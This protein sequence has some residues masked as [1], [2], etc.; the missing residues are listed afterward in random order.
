MSD[1]ALRTDAMNAVQ[2]VQ[3]H[4]NSQTLSG[5]AANCTNLRRLGQASY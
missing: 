3:M 2:A 1:L 4:Q 5:E